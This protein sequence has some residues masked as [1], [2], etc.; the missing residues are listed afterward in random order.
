VIL[1]RREIEGDALLRLVEE[2]VLAVEEE[3]DG[4]ADAIELRRA[5]V[6]RVALKDDN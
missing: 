1:V 6:H 5:L 4:A 2:E 3:Q